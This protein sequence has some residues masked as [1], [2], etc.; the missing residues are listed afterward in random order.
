MSGNLSPERK[1]AACAIDV[2]TSLSADNLHRLRAG[3]DGRRD[4]PTAYVS[5]RA[6][7]ELAEALEVLYPGV[8]DETLSAIE[9]DQ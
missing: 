3:S 5:R 9:A 7:R 2:L 8:L 6:L 4:R 1:L